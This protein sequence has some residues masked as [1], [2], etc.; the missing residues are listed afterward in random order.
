MSDCIAA[1]FVLQFLDCLINLRMVSVAP[2]NVPLCTV[3]QGQSSP[4]LP[5]RG[6]EE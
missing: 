5:G 1:G 2:T 6:R 4:D 3:T